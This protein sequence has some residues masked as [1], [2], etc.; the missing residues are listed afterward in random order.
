MALA[1]STRLGPYEI[2][3]KLGAGGMG[4]VYR[5]RD[6]RL[7][8]DVAVK[9]LP[10]AT[11]HEPQALA[12]LQREAKAVAALSHPNLLVLYDIGADNGL[13]YVVMEL[14]EGHTLGARL[15]QS[16]LD[17]A[18]TLRIATGVAD[19]L[20]AA[21]TKGIIHRDIKPDNI[22][23][24]SG[25]GVKVLD[26]GL[27]R[28]QPGLL[29]PGSP[30]TV[31]VETKP[32]VLMG[33]VAYMAPEQIRGQ[34]VDPSADVFAFGCVL[35][36]M[37]AH[38]RPFEGQSTA[39]VMASILHDPPP[40]LS[41]SGWQRPAEVDRLILRCLEKSPANRFPSARELAA[42][43]REI[44]GSP[45]TTPGNA[46]RRRSPSTPM[47]RPRRSAGRPAALRSPYCPS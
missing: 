16:P 25:G 40:A 4:E 7:E 5:A 17:L 21:H 41:A 2:L 33:T 1:T 26:F 39:D 15:K 18:E 44:A 6:M 37:L 38:R 3:A 13:T 10:E 42:G 36:E 43:L 45:W 47:T 22:F 29:G 20:A 8:R 12:R 27:A 31:T 32:G 14:L 34:Q 24:T 11:A 23:L 30:A 9:V 35:F 19:G 46:T 28:L